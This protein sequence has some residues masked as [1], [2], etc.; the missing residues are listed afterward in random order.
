MIGVDIEEVARFRKIDRARDRQFL[1]KIFTARE[2]D[3]CFS[4]KDPAP[5]LAARFCAK[6]AVI[7]ALASV[8][9]KTVLYRNIEIV[10]ETDGAPKA[11]L[12]T[13]DQIYKINVSISHTT[14]Y[15]IAF[16]IINYVRDRK[17][18]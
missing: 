15:A 11:R 8:K 3:Y 13:K 1:E 2:L 18:G 14:D 9:I 5:H 10:N 16:V 4:K 6:E 17:D 7:K 12:L